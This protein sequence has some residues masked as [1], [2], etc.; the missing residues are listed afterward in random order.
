[1]PGPLAQYHIKG[2]AEL[3][4]A[5]LQ[6]RREVLAELKPALIDVG[7]DVRRD[8]EANSIA[9][10]SNI[11]PKW[12]RMRI[13]VITS[14]VYVAPKSR[15]RGGSPRPNLAGLLL[16]SMQEAVDQNE[17]ATLAKFDALVDASA[18]AAGFF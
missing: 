14:G 15:R 11:G 4:R 2:A 12:S 10:I 16:T 6:L 13:G 1:M 9:G 18:A 8:A 17:A 5:L 7:E 3:D